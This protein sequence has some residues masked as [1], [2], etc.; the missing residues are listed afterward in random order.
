MKATKTPIYDQGV[1]ITK[2]WSN[3]MY[4]H[5]EKVAD[6]MKEQIQAALDKCEAQ[7]NEFLDAVD[8]DADVGPFDENIVILGRSLN[9]YAYG[10]GCDDFE[11]IHEDCIKGLDQV[12]N[13][14]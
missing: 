2:P 4:D 9:G 12:Q 6:L 10:Q 3:E 14:W 7:Y 13:H 8:L 5:N 1:L 11:Y